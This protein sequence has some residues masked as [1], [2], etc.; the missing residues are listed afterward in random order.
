M[1]FRVAAVLPLGMGFLL[2]YPLRWISE[3]L[4]IGEITM[5]L[6]VGLMIICFV[7]SGSVHVVTFLK[8][9]TISDRKKFFL[10]LAIFG[11]GVVLDIIGF[12]LVSPAHSSAS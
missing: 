5:F 2:L 4:W 11:A 9:L 8:V 12:T 3:G 1:F 6:S 7:L 10:L